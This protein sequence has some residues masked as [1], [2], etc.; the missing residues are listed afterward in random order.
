MAT[1]LVAVNRRNTSPTNSGDSTGTGRLTPTLK[2]LLV[3]AS[4]LAVFVITLVWRLESQLSIDVNVLSVSVDAVA[5]WAL[6][7]SLI[8][9]SL[10]PNRGHVAM[11][12]LGMVVLLL[13]V[14]S[15]GTSRSMAAQ[16]SI[17]LAACVGFTL[18]AQVILGT[19]RGTG[20][21][22]FADAESDDEGSLWM[23]RTIPLISLSLILMA[24][25]V[26]AN[27]TSRVLPGLQRVVQEQLQ[28]SLDVV[29]DRTG[30]GGTRYVRSGELGSIRQHIAA[31]PTEIS[32]VVKS[33]YMPGYLRGRVYDLYRKRRWHSASKLKSPWRPANESPNA[34][35]PPYRMEKS[36]LT[37]ECLEI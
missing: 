11:L 23:A 34:G 37:F 22:V 3:I 25:G 17:S 26:V 18:A 16:T 33:K 14:A 29:T 20:G 32:L 21:A 28:E 9:W 30:I 8:A 4:A 24:T 35:S 13:G 19:A 15:G 2:W 5:H 12:G 7:C 6:F 31:N 36:S 27:A 1:T 10:R